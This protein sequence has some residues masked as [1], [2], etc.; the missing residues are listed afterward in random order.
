MRLINAD[1]IHPDVR[2]QHGALAISQGQLAYAET[3]NAI[4]I[5]EDA[6]NGDVIKAMFPNTNIEY[7]A[8]YSTYNVEFPN[9]NDVKHFSYDWW[10][11]KYT[12]VS[13]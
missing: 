1:K 9:D 4:P 3:V 5:S 7:W 10:N 11:A 8:E 12:G 6:T 13:E 2:T